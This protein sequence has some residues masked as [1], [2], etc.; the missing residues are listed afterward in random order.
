MKTTMTIR[1]TLAALCL[2][3]FAC[4]PSLGETTASESDSDGGTGTNNPTSGGSEGEWQPCSAGNPCPDG[5]FCFNGLC[6]LGC[7]SDGDCAE[8]QYCATEGDRLCHNKVVTTCPEVACAEG[9]ECVNGYCSTPPPAT[10]CMPFTPDDGCDKNA[11]CLEVEEE[12]PKCYTFPYCPADGKCPVGL[13]GAVCNDELIAGKDK[14]CLVGAC[15]DASHCP[16]DFKCLM[17]GG[18]PLGYCSSGSFGE[19]CN[20]AADCDSNTC[21]APFPGVPGFCG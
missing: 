17:F 9:Q 14:I 10:E 21:N 6:A 8:D 15:L 4:N 20:V 7:N 18:D 1:S 11:L 3:L 16:A 12:M 19:P 13:Q 2:G 5:Q